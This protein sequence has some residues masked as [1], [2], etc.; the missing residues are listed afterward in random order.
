MGLAMNESWK[1]LIGLRERSL[2]EVSV[3]G[4]I[5]W[6]NAI[7]QNLTWLDEKRGYWQPTL[8]TNPWTVQAFWG[9]GEK[10]MEGQIKGRSLM[11]NWW[12]LWLFSIYDQGSGPKN[13]TFEKKEQTKAAAQKAPSP[14][15]ISVNYISLFELEIK[16]WSS[17]L[18]VLSVFLTFWTKRH[19]RQCEPRMV[20]SG[21]SYPVSL[22]DG[23]AGPGLAEPTSKVDP[24]YVSLEEKPLVKML[25]EV[26]LIVWVSCTIFLWSYFV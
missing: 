6:K 23:G 1:I 4:H 24:V 14:Y 20:L 5:L 16:N 26:T 21:E 25:L 9:A 12:S 10:G 22:W 13:Q 11:D 8:G 19:T 17:I 3:K 15:G 2:G 18:R 7:L